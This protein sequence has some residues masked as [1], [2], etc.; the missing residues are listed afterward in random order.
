MNVLVADHHRIVRA[1]IKALLSETG[2][3]QQF[4]VDEAETTEQAIEMVCSG[5]YGV[6]LMEYGLPGRGGIK[7]TELLTARRPDTCV[8]VLTDIDDGAQAERVIKAG[9]RGVILKNIAL[10]TLV[11]AIRTVIAGKTF[12]SNEI[13]IRLLERTVSPVEQ[14]ERLTA[15]EKEIFKAIME[16]LGGKEIAARMG[17]HKRTVDKHRQ[18]INYKL[19]IKTSLELVQAGLRMGLI[20]LPS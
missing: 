17:I 14:M 3:W 19:G 18:H 8:L 4:K 6:V 7:A 20:A 13:A 11:V 12:Y 9:A 10:E 16:G 15:R 2:S 5:E 1:G